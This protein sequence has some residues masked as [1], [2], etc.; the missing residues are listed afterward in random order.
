[1][2]AETGRDTECG[3]GGRVLASVGTEQPSH[4][5]FGFPSPYG[6]KY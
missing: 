5:A 2:R 6:R 4:K 1:M 3:S